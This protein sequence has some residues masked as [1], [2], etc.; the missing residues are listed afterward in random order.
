MN[1]KKNCVLFSGI[2]SSYTQ[3]SLL[4][5][6]PL[7]PADFLTTT[8]IGVYLNLCETRLIFNISVIRA[9]IYDSDYTVKCEFIAN[10][11]IKKAP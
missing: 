2:F 1:P 8:Q 5:K 9:S 3:N 11:G 10:M 4:N 6:S 7:F